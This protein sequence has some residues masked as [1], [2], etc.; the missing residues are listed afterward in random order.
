MCGVFFLHFLL[1]PTCSIKREGLMIINFIKHIRTLSSY[2]TSL[3]KSE[4]IK[5]IN[6]LETIVAK[7]KTFL[8][9]I[10]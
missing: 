4:R 3:K 5:I 7:V 2:E 8:I 1:A 10:N 6:F 9:N